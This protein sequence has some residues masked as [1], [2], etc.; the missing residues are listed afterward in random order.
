[1]LF[2]ELP[3]KMYFLAAKNWKKNA[4]QDAYLECGLYNNYLVSS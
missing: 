3:N 1:M 4:K 2:K